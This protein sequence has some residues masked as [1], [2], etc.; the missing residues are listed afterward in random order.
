MRFKNRNG[1]FVPHGEFIIPAGSE[2]LSEYLIDGEE[3]PATD[4]R[5]VFY[6]AVVDTINPQVIQIVEREKFDEN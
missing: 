5:K 2:T 6:Y 3:Q 1:T 4:T